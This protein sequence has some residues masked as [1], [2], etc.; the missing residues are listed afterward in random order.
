MRFVNRT[1]S[2][3]ALIE[4]ALTGESLYM[5][6]FISFDMQMRVEKTKHLSI[7]SIGHSHNCVYFLSKCETYITGVNILS[8][9]WISY[10]GTITSFLDAKGRITVRANHQG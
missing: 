5:G 2:K 6:T 3:T 9:Q 7:D 10:P 8:F 1:K 4:T